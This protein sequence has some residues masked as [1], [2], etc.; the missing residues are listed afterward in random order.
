MTITALSKVLGVSTPTIYRRL[1]AQGVNIDDLRDG[2]ELTQ[3]GVQVIAS[4]CDRDDL[5]THGVKCNVS[6][7]EHEALHE[8]LQGET[9]LHVQVAALQAQVNGLQALVSQ[10]EAQR[11]DLRRLLDA[12]NAALEREQT[13]RQ[14]E[15]LLLAAGPDDRRHWWQKIFNIK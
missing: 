9:A 6:D 5:V 10:L 2:G 15:R 8:A 7:T 12:A 1:K 4:R 13:D 14:A 3:H 11:D